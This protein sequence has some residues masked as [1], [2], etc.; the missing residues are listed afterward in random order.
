MKLYHYSTGSNEYVIWAK[1]K[2]AA[3]IRLNFPSSYASL[4]SDQTS[5]KALKALVPD[6]SQQY[7]RSLKNENSEWQTF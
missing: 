1:S 5:N 2:L 7:W 3:L 6:K 4:L